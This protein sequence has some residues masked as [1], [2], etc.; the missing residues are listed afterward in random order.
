MGREISSISRDQNVYNTAKNHN[1]SGR[2]AN[3]CCMNQSWPCEKSTGCSLCLIHQWRGWQRAH[4]N[5]VRQLRTINFVGY[6]HVGSNL[7]YKDVSLLISDFATPKMLWLS[8]KCLQSCIARATTFR[9]RYQTLTASYFN[10]THSL[11]KSNR[12]GSASK[13]LNRVARDTCYV[14]SISLKN[15]NG[16]VLLPNDLLTRAWC[17]CPQCQVTR[18]QNVRSVLLGGMYHMIWSRES[19]ML[20]TRVC[21]KILIVDTSSNCFTPT[22]RKLLRCNNYSDMSFKRSSQV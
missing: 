20:W 1:M 6:R 13:V 2:G 7:I 8:L 21:S 3:K 14:R 16:G 22:R 12:K 19:R 11:S 15:S 5:L 10:G 17:H 18:H 9:T 4:W